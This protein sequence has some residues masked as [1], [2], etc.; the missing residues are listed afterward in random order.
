MN[1]LIILWNVPEIWNYLDI[2]F[3]NGL[4]PLISSVHLHVFVSFLETIQ[5]SEVE[6]IIYIYILYIDRNPHD[7]SFLLAREKAKQN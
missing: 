2:N 7:F 6:P 4:A 1:G 3:E 5:M